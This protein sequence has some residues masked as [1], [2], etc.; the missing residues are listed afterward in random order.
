MGI[1]ECVARTGS[2]SPGAA[3]A[4]WLA[5]VSDSLRCHRRRAWLDR[6][7]VGF[8]PVGSVKDTGSPFF[9]RSGAPDCVSTERMPVSQVARSIPRRSACPRGFDR[10]ASC[11][12]AS[13]RPERSGVRQATQ[14]EPAD[15]PRGGKNT[16]GPPHRPGA[17]QTERPDVRS[18]RGDPTRAR[19]RQWAPAGARAR[20]QSQPADRDLTHHATCPEDRGAQLKQPFEAGRDKSARPE[21]EPR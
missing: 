14:R 8:R 4:Q 17:A 13:T 18:S 3:T 21:G 15:G 11:T 16:T 9:S 5:E 10:L 1:A 2:G 20:S 12:P 19:L 7:A 6:R